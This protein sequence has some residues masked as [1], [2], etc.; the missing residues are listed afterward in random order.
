MQVNS[1]QKSFES[2]RTITHKKFQ[3]DNVNKTNNLKSIIL[4]LRDCL[5]EAGWP[6]KLKYW[7]ETF[8]CVHMKNVH[9]MWD[10]DKVKLQNNYV[11]AGIKPLIDPSL[12][13]RIISEEATADV[14]EKEFLKT[15]FLR[16]SR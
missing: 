11:L 10:K 12:V 3:L 13:K 2:V 7:N 5:Y 6:G 16:F 9:G 15:V 14:L 8:C 1:K 4:R